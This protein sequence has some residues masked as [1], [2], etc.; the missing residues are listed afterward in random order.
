MVAYRKHNEKMLFHDVWHCLAICI[1]YLEKDVGLI[2]FPRLSKDNSVA[3]NNVA[4]VRKDKKSYREND[5]V[6][7]RWREKFI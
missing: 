1:I 7:N 3:T 6:L 4:Q 5:R 2:R